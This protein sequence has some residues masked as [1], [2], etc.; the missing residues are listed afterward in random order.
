M[1]RRP[2]VARVA[3]SVVMRALPHRFSTYNR[4]S[5]LHAYTL[6]QISVLDGRRKAAGYEKWYREMSGKAPDMLRSV[7]LPSSD[8]LGE[9]TR[10]YGIVFARRIAILF[11][12]GEHL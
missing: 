4:A 1:R 12:Q 5:T 11:E 8:R 3:G 7:T 2:A 6:Y 9:K 10:Q